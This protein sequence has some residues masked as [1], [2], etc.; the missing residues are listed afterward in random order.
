MTATINEQQPYPTLHEILSHRRGERVSDLRD[1]VYNHLSISG[2]TS[3][4]EIGG[5]VFKVDYQKSVS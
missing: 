2:V 5:M 3:G 4:L 1:L